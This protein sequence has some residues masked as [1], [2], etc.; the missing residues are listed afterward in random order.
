MYI[1]ILGDTHMPRMAKKL[2]APLISEL[3]KADLILHTGDFAAVDLL[4]ELKIYA[5]VEAVAGN[6]DGEELI[7][8]LGKKKVL[9]LGGA[10]IGLTHGDGK[11]KTTERRAVD[12]FSGDTVDAV[13]FGHSHIPVKKEEDGVWLFNPGSPTDKRRQSQFSFGVMH[14]DG[15][16]ISE[17][18]HIYYDRKDL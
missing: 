18:K 6:V 17:L 15:S 8:L 7:G 13:I 16:G 1:V 5:P 9:Q 10:T 11:G 14:V 4:N 3:E 2:P 12:A